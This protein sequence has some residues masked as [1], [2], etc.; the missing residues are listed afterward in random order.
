MTIPNTRSLDPGSNQRS[1]KKGWKY[2]YPQYPTF[3][4]I[5]FRSDSLDNEP[6]VSCYSF[7]QKFAPS[8]LEIHP[9]EKQKKHRGARKCSH[10]NFQTSGYK[11]LQQ[12]TRVNWSLLTWRL[13]TLPKTTT[14][15]KIGRAPKGNDRIPTI[16]FQGRLLLVSGR[17]VSIDLKRW[18]VTHLFGIFNHV[19]FHSGYVSPKIQPICLFKKRWIKFT[20]LI[21]YHIM[22]YWYHIISS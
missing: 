4:K 7:F 18:P 11:L 20:L 5:S 9:P 16:H 14:A 19:H 17:V 12:V 1:T 21:W 10:V 8:W 6:L 15:L 22:S 2:R 13:D 3:G